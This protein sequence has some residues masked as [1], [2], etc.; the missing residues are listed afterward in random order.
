MMEVL[1]Q[2]ITEVGSS[3]KDHA[4]ASVRT[5]SVPTLAERTPPSTAQLVTESH[6][7]FL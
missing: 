4:C 2:T 1:V 5:L 3:H 6:A 7:T